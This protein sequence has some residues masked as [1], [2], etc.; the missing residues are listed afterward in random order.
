MKDIS[1]YARIWLS[2]KCHLDMTKGWE[3]SCTNEQSTFE[4][5]SS[6]EISCPAYSKNLSPY[7]K[8]LIK[9]IVLR[10]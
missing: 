10:N 1:V 9:L 3:E 5:N 2:C 6:D 7:Q 4:L 8:S